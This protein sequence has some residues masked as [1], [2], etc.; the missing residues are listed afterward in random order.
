MLFRS[1]SGKIVKELIIG[2]FS[3]K[4]TGGYGFSISSYIRPVGEETTYS[5]Q[6]QLTMLVNRDLNAFRD[7]TISKLNKEN[8]NSISFSYPG[9]SSF[10]LSKT[11]KGWLVNNEAADSNSV[12]S[13]L[14]T[15]ANCS[16]YEFEDE[17]SNATPTPIYK[18]KFQG[19]NMPAVE[20]NAFPSDSLKQYIISSTQN[21]GV[22]FISG[23][24]KLADRIFISKKKLSA[25]KK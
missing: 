12:E 14:N 20:I 8:L 23:K 9:D 13:Y 2:K 3:Y 11:E 22:N 16:G 5:V 6:S 7:K 21:E 19:S 17:T 24:S 1:V 18:I 15:I 10:T 4:Q 25:E